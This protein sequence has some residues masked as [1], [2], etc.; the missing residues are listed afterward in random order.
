MKNDISI[1]L[2][3]KLFLR[4]FL[5]ILFS[6]WSYIPIIVGILSPM[7]I[8]LPIAYASWI[9]PSLIPGGLLFDAYIPISIEYPFQ[10]VCILVIEIII[11][12]GGIFVFLLGLYHLTKGKKQKVLIVTTG[13]YHYIRHPQNLGICLI[14]LPFA[15]YIPGFNDLGVRIGEIF[16]WLLFTF[17]LTIYSNLEEQSL[18]TKFSKEYSPYQHYTG[19]FFPKLPFRMKIFSKKGLIMTT[20]KRYALLSLSYIISVIV[21]FFIIEL[22]LALK[23]ITLILY[24]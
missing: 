4:K 17:I 21:V 10:Y 18:L 6:V 24:F 14:V 19:F 15:L 13:I 5:L 3:V 8:I 22:L 20:Q 1:K 9:I 11:F 12:I 7:L 16:S 23:L 2:T